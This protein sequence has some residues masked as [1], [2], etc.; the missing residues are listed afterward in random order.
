MLSVAAK[1]QQ[2]AAGL[3]LIELIVALSIS[4]LLLATALPAFTQLT[5]HHQV[6]RSAEAL[7]L[8]LERARSEAITRNAAIR[9]TLIDTT[10]R[11]GWRI[12]CVH[13]TPACP[14]SL[15][16]AAAATSSPIRWRY[17]TSLA[18]TTTAVASNAMSGQL[19]PTS[20]SFNALGQL[21][22]RL[23]GTPQLQLEV[24]HLHDPQAYR[25]MV[26]VSAAGAIR[27]CDP[28]AAL[29]GPSACT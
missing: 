19:K 11:P 10:G 7:K 24:S 23:P 28:S 1:G 5:R 2:Q 18:P 15:Q 25:R 14:T 6:Q 21:A 13:P 20:I 29:R 22:D 26:R 12:D 27:L 4:T 3:T 9:L 16:V 17:L 8:A